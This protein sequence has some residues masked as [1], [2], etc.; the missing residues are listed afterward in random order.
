MSVNTFRFQV[1][2]IKHKARL[3]VLKT[4][5]GSVQTPVFMPVGTAATVKALTSQDILDLEFQILLA[6]TY[7]L[8]LR[9]GGHH[10]VA[11][12]G[13]HQFMQWPR[14]V[15]TDS[16]GFQAFSL[17][18]Q[19]SDLKLA[20]VSENGVSFQSHLDGS[21]QLLSPERS[22]ELQRQIGADIIMA[23][24]DMTPDTADQSIAEDTVM[25]TTRWAARSAA[26]WQAQTKTSHFGRYQALF[27]IV[28]GGLSPEFRRKSAQDLTAMGFD[29]LALGGETIGYNMAVTGQVL[30]WVIDILPP[31]LPRY[32]MG[33]GREPVDLVEL[34][35][36]G[37]DMFDCVGPTRLARN[38]VL[39]AGGVE[40][41][42]G[43]PRYASTWHRHR[44]RIGRAEF[45]N[46]HQL[47]MADSNSP[48]TE[49]GYSYAYLH[50]LYMAKELTYYRLATLHNLWMM[51]QTIDQLRDWIA[52]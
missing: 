3:G 8:G 34:V 20:Q 17:G 10:L 23:F 21:I 32:A 6:N 14:V 19:R 45:K 40:I 44:I 28:Q 31:E 15:L 16:G 52:S 51:A 25:R 27:G 9:P 18:K 12:G 43:L 49:M 46:K 7:H 1:N 39:F 29:G 26:Y 11:A 47:F 41:V 5:H 37:Y 48:L 24:D 22:I 38:G 13:V 35:L 33:A 4:S 50:H 30:D 36:A 42:D 2:K